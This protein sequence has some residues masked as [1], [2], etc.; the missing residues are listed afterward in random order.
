MA[1]RHERMNVWETLK[2]LLRDQQFRPV[3]CV[4]SSFFCHSR[5]HHSCN[6]LIPLTCCPAPSLSCPSSS[7]PPAYI[8]PLFSHQVSECLSSCASEALL[9]CLVLPVA[10]RIFCASLFL[11]FD[12]FVV[13]WLKFLLFFPLINTLGFLP[14]TL[15]RYR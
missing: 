11:F 9:F 15:R 2:L 14:A 12:T 3:L 5:S 4:S 7:L 6:H 10:L 1:G 13:S 8:L